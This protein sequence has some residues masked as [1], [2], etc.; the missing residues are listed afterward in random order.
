MILDK[1]MFVNSPNECKKEVD[2]NE[3]LKRKEKLK[4]D[5]ETFLKEQ[6]A[7]ANEAIDNIKKVC[8]IY[9]EDEDNYCVLEKL[10]LNKKNEVMY[11]STYI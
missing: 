6:V 3:L 1:D 4:E 9:P 2:V 7:K 5:T 10:T 8:R 11:Q